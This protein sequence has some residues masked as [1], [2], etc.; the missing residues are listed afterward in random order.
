[1]PTVIRNESGI[2]IGAQVENV[3]FVPKG[4]FNRDWRKFTAWAAAQVPPVSLADVPVVPPTDAQRQRAQLLREVD[5]N[6]LMR[7]FAL[8]LFDEIN[9][10]RASFTPPLPARTMNQFIN[11]IKARIT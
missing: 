1:M 8:T 11:A 4:E 3:G 10:I 2:V 5:E 6:K 9:T 7:A